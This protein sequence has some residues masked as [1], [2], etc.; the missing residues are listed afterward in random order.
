M[1]H[2]AYM[3][4]V[5]TRAMGVVTCLRRGAWWT[6]RRRRESRQERRC[7]ATR[8]RGRTEA[9]STAADDEFARRHRGREGNLSAEAFS[10][11]RGPFASGCSVSALRPNATNERS[12]RWR[13]PPVLYC[14]WWNLHKIDKK[15][16]HSTVSSLVF[17]WLR[18]DIFSCIYK[19]AAWPCDRQTDR[20][21]D[22]RP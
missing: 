10:T 5:P 8:R 15:L 18:D 3:C 11:D 20:Q 7:A 17:C 2:D 21:T 22:P 14:N 13:P 12:Q 9:W 1:A 16:H 4:T 19:T 6:C